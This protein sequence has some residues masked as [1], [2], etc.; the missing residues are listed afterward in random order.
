[1]KDDLCIHFWRQN[2][3]G[4]A[5]H[6]YQGHYELSFVT[7]AVLLLRQ[8]SI[9]SSTSEWT[10]SIPGLQSGQSKVKLFTTVT[11]N[12]LCMLK[13]YLA[14]LT[15]SLYAILY[16]VFITETKT[17]YFSAVARVSLVNPKTSI[18]VMTLNFSKQLQITYPCGLISSHI[19]WRTLKILSAS[20]SPPPY[21]WGGS[22][23]QDAC[24]VYNTSW[25]IDLMRID[26]CYNKT[27]FSDRAKSAVWKDH[28]P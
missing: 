24:K 11:L 10:K 6:W 12:Y 8:C 17:R 16:N 14:C 13:E 3:S 9:Q 20:F 19:N 21:P 1:M 25:H 26:L 27:K 18:F 23:K 15:K 22:Q 2:E 5:I 7:V 28:F 4:D